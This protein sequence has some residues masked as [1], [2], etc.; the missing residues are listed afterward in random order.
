MLVSAKPALSHSRGRVAPRREA[1][2]LLSL[3][4]P[5]GEATRHLPLGLSSRYAPEPADLFIF[6]TA[7]FLPSFC[8][9]SK[10]P[11]CVLC[12]VST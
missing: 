5:K 2:A 8:K 11:C 3:Q 9:S 6:I 1:V 4:A 12:D 7:P 10:L